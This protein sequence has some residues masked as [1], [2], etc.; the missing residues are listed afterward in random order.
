MQRSFQRGGLHA[1][2][3]GVA[4]R[5]V[6]AAAGG[7]RLLGRVGHLPGVDGRSRGLAR[8]QHDGRVGNHR[9]DGRASHRHNSL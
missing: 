7:V 1:G 6:G 3:D 4:A 8:Q 9:V 2:R 5:A